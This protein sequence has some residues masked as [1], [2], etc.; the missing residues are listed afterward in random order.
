MKSRG[1]ELD[2]YGPAE[3]ESTASSR[4]DAEAQGRLLVE[5][6]GNGLGQ[7]EAYLDDE[8]GSSDPLASSSSA[9]PRRSPRP[10]RAKRTAHRIW[11]PLACVLT[12]VVLLVAYSW[13][14]PHFS[15]LPPLPH[16][17]I[18]PGSSGGA[19]G[20]AGQSAASGMCDCPAS[21]DG[22]GSA[23]QTEETSRL[24]NVYGRDNLARSRL[25]EG[26]SNRVRRFL[27]KAQQGGPV[28]IGILGGSGTCPE[29]LTPPA[30]PR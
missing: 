21:A 29:T 14:H 9:S 28:K 6:N 25:F 11:R 17:S 5:S 1:I 18:T 4:S 2:A 23:G 22:L 12:P 13:I 3:G 8:A 16:V 15:A 20:A 19:T 10:S 30:V 26:S 7:S 27:H 24:C